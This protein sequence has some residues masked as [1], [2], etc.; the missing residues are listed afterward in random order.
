MT[1]SISDGAESVETRRKRLRFRSW[2]R[3]TREMDLLMGS[4]ADAHIG[5]F[6]HPQ[7]DRFEALLELGD[8]DLY[9][10]MNGRAPV[11]AEHDSDVM[12]LL[13]DFR[14]TPRQGS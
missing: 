1:D 12:R 6:D 14:Y 7:L 10:W 9:D 5:S 13:M 2:H 3:G 8:P 4:F 11:P